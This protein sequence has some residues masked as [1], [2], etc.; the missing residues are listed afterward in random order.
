[1]AP[2]RLE[3]SNHAKERLKQ[4]LITRNLIR[5]TLALGKLVGTDLKGR[6]IKQKKFG[7]RILIVVYM[8]NMGGQSVI[9][10]YWKGEFL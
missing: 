10:S 8:E 9:T 5:K 7:K 3:I 1:M 2:S 4:R 6:K